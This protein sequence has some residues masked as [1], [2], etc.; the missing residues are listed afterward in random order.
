MK[1]Q[2]IA[3]P[4]A[5]IDYLK[6][7]EIC[8][9]PVVEK[10]ENHELFKLIISERKLAVFAESHVYAVWDFMCLMKALQRKLSCMETCWYPPVDSLG[11]HLVNQIIS[12]EESDRTADGRYLSHFEMYLEGME[13]CGADINGVSSFINDIRSNLQLKEALIKNSVPNSAKKFVLETFEIF[14]M[15]AHEIAASFCFARENLTQRMFMPILESLAQ[16]KNTKSIEKFL[17]YFRRHIE[18]DG[19]E[20]GENAKN[21]LLNL[22]MSDDEKW[23]ECQKST[24]FSLQSRL[25]FLNGIQ[26]NIQAS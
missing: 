14:D 8:I 12:E 22:C 10:I 24:L 23:E 11:C 25:K 17:F 26:K 18:L 20:H 6:E 21:L 7:L 15:K 13:Q 16:N 1:N 2:L 9:S 5:P 3:H 4:K 19:E